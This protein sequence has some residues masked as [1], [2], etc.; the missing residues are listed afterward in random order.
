MFSNEGFPAALGG[1]GKETGFDR[2][3]C[4]PALRTGAAV[5]F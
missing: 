3:D 1:S 5:S 4:R 2:V